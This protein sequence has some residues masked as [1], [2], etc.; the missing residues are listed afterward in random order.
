VSWSALR[1][2][3]RLSRHGKHTE[4]L[5]RADLLLSQNPQDPRIYYQLAL[6]QLEA[7]QPDQAWHTLEQADP[8]QPESPVLS[9]YRAL[10]L[11]QMERWDEGLEQAELLQRQCPNHQFMA[12]LFCYLYL[13]LGDVSRALQPL[14]IGKPA[15]WVSWFRPELAA[16]A[17]LLSRLL[18]QLELYLLPL[19]FSVLSNSPALQEPKPIETPPQRLSL[20][21]LLH[22]ILGLYYQRKGIHYWEKGLTHN[23]PQRR[24]QYLEKS[25][26]AQKLAVE[27][28]P[29]QFRGYYHLGEALLYA[30]STPDSMVPNR[31]RL[32]EAER[33]F[34]HSWAQEGPNPY[35]YF[36]LGRT[37]QLLG[38]PAAAR[39]YFER[40]LAKFDKFPEAHYALGQVF[41]LMGQ[42]AQAREWLKRSVSSDFLPVARERLYELHQALQQ[43]Q[44][45]CRPTMPLWPPIEPTV[46]NDP[47]TEDLQSI[48]TSLDSIEETPE[49]HPGEDPW[50]HPENRE[51]CPD[52]PD[53]PSSEHPANPPEPKLDSTH[54]PD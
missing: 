40:A 18:V 35:L 6:V 47:T 26:Q 44:V 23:D 25:L 28:E 51:T 13:G 21:A 29:L 24:H 22:S 38:Q 11:G 3:V 43:G 42:S 8:L 52:S 1:Q 49:S 14:E 5:A 7:D 4:A 54:P 9:L 34:V 27:H 41:L 48:Q 46:D 53:L 37:V 12:S 39:T 17:P 30:S 50:S 10:V 45:T 36:Y 19:E 33:C 20:Q 31:E 15:G 16:F 32:L 2:T